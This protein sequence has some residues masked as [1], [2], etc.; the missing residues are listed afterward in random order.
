MPDAHNRKSDLVIGALKPSNRSYHWLFVWVITN[1]L[2][3]TVWLK[4]G[5]IPNLGTMIALSTVVFGYMFL[6]D[7]SDKVWWTAD[8]IWSRRWDY[9]SIRPTCHT[10]SLEAITEVKTAY[11]PANFVVGK[12]FDCFELVSPSDTIAILPSFHRR[13]ELEDLL[14]IVQARRP[15][16]FVDPLVEKFMEG[17]YSDWWRYRSGDRF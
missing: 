7:I 2:L 17:D 9:L 16:A 11:H 12:P 10:A 3:A 6:V 1:A 14:R 8:Q 4:R 13:E 15:Q 5:W